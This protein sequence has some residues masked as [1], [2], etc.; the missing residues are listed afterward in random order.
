MDR[1]RTS[2]L[3]ELIFRISV[4][5]KGAFAVLEM[6]LGVALL[7]IKPEFI[8]RAVAALTQDELAEDSRD[9]IANH[10]LGLVEHVAIDS[11]NFAAF[12]LLIH[13]VVK[14]VLVAALLK[15]K[16]SVFPWAMA[17]FGGFILYQF[18]RFTF[19]HSLGLI[20]L[21]VFDGAVIWLIWLEHRAHGVRVV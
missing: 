10:V 1:A 8:M 16:F 20:A 13:G 5:L 14:I 11:R 18:Y 19:T 6:I 7:V 3:R 4:A 15:E 2:R 17:V 21:S 12:Y 9:F